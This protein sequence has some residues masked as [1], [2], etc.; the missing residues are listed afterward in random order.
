MKNLIITILVMVFVIGGAIAGYFLWQN[1]YGEFPPEPV[2]CAMDAKLCPDGS[3][4]GRTGP[5]C[6]FSECPTV[7]TRKINLFYY[8]P[9]LDKDESGNIGCSRNGLV[10]VEK[11]ILITQT[12]IQDAIKLLLSGNLT[13]KEKA[14]GI[15]TEYPLP[16]FSLD[17]ANLDKNGVLTLEFD[18][19]QNKTV[20]GSCRVGILWFQIEATA[21]QFD[22]VK[23][24]KFL[25][26]DIFQP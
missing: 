25:P 16:G 10:A 2:F 1:K 21:K 18:D 7:G 8:N 15:S 3:Y 6:E 14:Q 20:G 23:E 19:S 5:K 11:R 9:E 13:T 26:E 17:S 22:E 24:V 4:V 12:P